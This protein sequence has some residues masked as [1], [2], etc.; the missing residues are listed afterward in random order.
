MNCGA[1]VL[2]SWLLLLFD[3]DLCLVVLGGAT[4]DPLKGENDWLR[5][6]PT[7]LK[8]SAGEVMTADLGRSPGITGAGDGDG[9]LRLKGLFRHRAPPAAE[10]DILDWLPG[11]NPPSSWV[12]IVG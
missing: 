10:I 7:G 11:F 12:A 1:N 3:T 6:W 2:D 4:V 5:L 8:P 9:E